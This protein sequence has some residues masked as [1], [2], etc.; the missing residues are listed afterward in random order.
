MRA[1]IHALERSRRDRE[2][3]S[4][5]R[6]RTK[7]GR[8]EVDD[9]GQGKGTLDRAGTL[10]GEIKLTG[11]CNAFSA[12]CYRALAPPHHGDQSGVSYPLE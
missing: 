9:H 8:R 10:V 6:T 7:I 5:M 12:D 4:A 3:I 1:I 11:V 2:D